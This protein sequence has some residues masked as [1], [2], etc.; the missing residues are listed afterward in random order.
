VRT[1]VAEDAEGQVVVK[2][3]ESGE[4]EITR[5]RKSYYSWSPAL[6]IVADETSMLPD[7]KDEA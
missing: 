3:A 1:I 2:L 7:W 4:V 6:K 5:R